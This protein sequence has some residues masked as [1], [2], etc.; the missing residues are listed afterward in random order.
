MD[1]EMEVYILNRSWKIRGLNAIKDL[2]DWLD[3]NASEI[4]HSE[5]L[6]AAPPAP[7]MDDIMPEPTNIGG[8]T[9]AV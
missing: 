2:A 1:F 8:T 6:A 5:D 4:C 7:P 3:A 9:R